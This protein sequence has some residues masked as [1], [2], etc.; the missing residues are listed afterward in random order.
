[1]V[2]DSGTGVRS[3]APRFPDVITVPLTSGSVI[4]LSAVGFVTVKVVSYTS[5]EDPSN[6]IDESDKYKPETVGLTKDLFVIPV[7]VFVWVSMSTP[8]DCT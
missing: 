7:T 6:I 8:L 5:A 1:M 4:V 3:T 2:P